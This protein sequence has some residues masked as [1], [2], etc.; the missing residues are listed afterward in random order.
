MSYI[1]K[2]VCK[3]LI[4]LSVIFRISVFNGRTA[5]LM[6]SLDVFTNNRQESKKGGK[7]CGGEDQNYY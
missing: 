7:F 2:F 4:F 1:P 5:L 6:T 3:Y